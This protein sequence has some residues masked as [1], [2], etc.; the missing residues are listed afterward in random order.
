MAEL[1]SL[2][3]WQVHL[4]AAGASGMTVADYARRHGLSLSAMYSARYALK[5][6]KA[7]GARARVAHGGFVRVVAPSSRGRL[8][9]R[10]PNGVELA[11][12][13]DDAGTVQAVLSA[14]WML[15]CGA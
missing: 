5:R 2:D 1:M 10:L 4:E 9:A 13:A 8:T 12:E 15:R 14:L 11:L 3:E 6:R 7:V